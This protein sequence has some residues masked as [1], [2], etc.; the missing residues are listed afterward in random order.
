MT[1]DQIRSFLGQ[2]RRWKNLDLKCRKVFVATEREYDATGRVEDHFQRAYL[3][4]EAQGG[5]GTAFAPAEWERLPL[6]KGA[7][8]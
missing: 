3:L 1:E 8:K 4:A 2:T 5:L 6:V 7:K